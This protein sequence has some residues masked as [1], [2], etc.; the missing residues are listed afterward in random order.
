MDEMAAAA[1]KDPVAF[2]LDH[3][4]DPRARDVLK[5]AAAMAGLKRKIHDF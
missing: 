3:L 1:G 4:S 5:R 2:R